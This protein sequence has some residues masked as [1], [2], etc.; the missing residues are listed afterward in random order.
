MTKNLT[1]IN[2]N[3]KLKSKYLMGK[4]HMVMKEKDRMMRMIMELKRVMELK[5]KLTLMVLK[6]LLAIKSSNKK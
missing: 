4:R 3:H 1:F 6:C 5:L 2:I